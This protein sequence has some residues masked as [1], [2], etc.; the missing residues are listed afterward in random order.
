MIVDFANFSDFMLTLHS[1]EL[2]WQFHLS[3][4]T[5]LHVIH[6]MYLFTES[7]VQ[8]ILDHFNDSCRVPM[9]WINQMTPQ[10][11]KMLGR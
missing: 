1:F 6:V 3:V 10:D 2:F 9:N 11:L 7:V 8:L 5:I 4:M